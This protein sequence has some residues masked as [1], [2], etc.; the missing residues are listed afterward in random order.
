[1][2]R[3]PNASSF[4]APAAVTTLRTRYTPHHFLILPIAPWAESFSETELANPAGPTGA[5]PAAPLERVTFLPVADGTVIADEPDRVVATEEDLSVDGQPLTSAVV[6]FHVDLIEGTVASARLRLYPLTPVGSPLIASPT[7]VSWEES[8]L[9]YANRPARLSPDSAESL[10]GTDGWVEIDVT[11]FIVSDRVSFAIEQSSSTLTRFSSREGIKPPEL[12]ITLAPTGNEPPSVSQQEIHVDSSTQSWKPR[13]RDD[14]G[15]TLT[16]RLQTA[17]QLG[18]AEVRPDCSLISYQPHTGSVGEDRF[19]Y[20]VSDGIYSVEVRTRLI[21][22]S[23]VGEPVASDNVVFVSD[24]DPTEVAL[25]GYDPDGVCPLRF[26][27]SS[28]WARSPRSGAH[29]DTLSVLCSTP[30]PAR[31]RRMRPH[32]TMS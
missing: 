31:Y 7:H 20:M 24:V 2:S 17:P 10:A 6:S 28:L 9:S 21:L 12:V 14:D 19:G 32:S 29:T 22:D 23:A 11:P 16:C 30:Q 3:R 18:T 5:E 13:V 1:M 8:S 15:D 26:E 25:R 27:I 4:S